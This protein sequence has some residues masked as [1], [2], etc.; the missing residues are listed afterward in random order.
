MI[1]RIL[2]ITIISCLFI[3]KV[4]GHIDLEL[5]L[6]VYFITRP[7]RI[8]LIIL[9]LCFILVAIK[10]VLNNNTI[11]LITALILL[12]VLVFLSNEL[13]FVIIISDIII[14]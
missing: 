7:V 8:S 4:L 13:L 1:N 2:I 5:R 12:H 11:R 6:V 14:V 10:A 3:L 9:S